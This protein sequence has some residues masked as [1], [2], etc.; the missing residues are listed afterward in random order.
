[1][2]GNHSSN[3]PIVDDPNPINA[4]KIGIVIRE[5]LPL[6]ILRSTAT[7]PSNAPDLITNVTDANV[8]NTRNAI[9]AALTMPS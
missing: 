4:M 5:V 7:A 3:I 6:N 8:M 9:S 1:M 2:N